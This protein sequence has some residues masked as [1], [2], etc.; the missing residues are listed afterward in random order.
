MNT[1]DKKKSSKYIMYPV[2]TNDLYSWAMSQYLP[3]GGFWWMTEKEKDK[4]GLTKYEEDG[5]KR[6]NFRSRFGVSKRTT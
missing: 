2:D 4:T 5:K 1:Y 3:T 6:I